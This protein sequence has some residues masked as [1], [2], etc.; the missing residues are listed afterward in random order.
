MRKTF[1][2]RAGRSAAIA[3]MAVM[4]LAMP[5]QGLAAP[6]PGHAAPSTGDVSL[7]EALASTR[8]L[9]NL[10][11]D[12]EFVEGETGM[13]L[14]E[15]IEPGIWQ[16]DVHD[17]GAGI[18]GRGTFEELFRL[19]I[20]E[21]T[22]PDEE[23]SE[24]GLGSL[25]R[26]VVAGFLTGSTGHRTAL[27]GL[28]HELVFDD[29]TLPVVRVLTPLQTTPGIAAAIIS[30][31]DFD[32]FI[33]LASSVQEEASAVDPRDLTAGYWQCVGLVLLCEAYTAA[34][35]AA[36]PACYAACAAVCASPGIFLCV[37]CIV[38]CTGGGIAI[39]QAAFNCWQSASQNGCVP[40]A[41]Y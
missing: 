36:A 8:L 2:F 3:S 40:W 15:E 27:T 14:E 21:L 19:P 33:D 38:A 23:L 32:V 29:D 20:P 12:R 25:K 39:C 1:M 4:T 22:P 17:T 10:A 37:S 9:W 11:W 28:V 41:A 24:A 5:A 31:V 13:A 26:C 18:V 35:F 7:D 30:A 34:C 6:R 16:L